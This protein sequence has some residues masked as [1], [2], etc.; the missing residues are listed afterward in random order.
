MHTPHKRA[1][2]GPDDPNKCPCEITGH[3]HSSPC[4]G[5]LMGCMLLRPTLTVKNRNRRRRVIPIF[6]LSD[7]PSTIVR[8]E[9]RHRSPSA[10]KDELQGR[11]RKSERPKRSVATQ[12]FRISSRARSLRM[13]QANFPAPAGAFSCVKTRKGSGGRWGLAPT[14]WQMKNRARTLPHIYRYRE[15]L[16]DSGQ[17]SRLAFFTINELQF[18]IHPIFAVSRDP[19]FTYIN[20][21]RE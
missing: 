15:G 7:H 11:A 14:P 21:I 12:V 20:H 4:R 18:K 6:Y 16:A 19:L 2:Q 9:E 13:Y 3:P 8:P 1:R 5:R 10:R 17:P